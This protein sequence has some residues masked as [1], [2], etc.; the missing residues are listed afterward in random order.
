MP[1]NPS[2]PDSTPDDGLRDKIFEIIKGF[3]PIAKGDGNGGE[4]PLGYDLIKDERTEYGFY[5]EYEDMEYCA[6]KLVSAIR[7][8]I[9]SALPMKQAEEMH[10]AD[11][12]DLINLKA[13][14]Y[15]AAISEI[16]ANLK[17]KGLL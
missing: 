14:G 2:L 4:V 16:E 13:V 15:N 1:D 5:W 7:A 9:Q 17:K 8:A 10:T 3:E 12:R 6:E 11:H